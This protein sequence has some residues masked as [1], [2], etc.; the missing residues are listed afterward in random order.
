MK[1]EI[2]DALNYRYA[3]KS[4]DTA[5]SVSDVDLDIIL[6]SLRLAPSSFGLE[7]WGFVVVN[8]KSK[9]QEVA[10]A[11]WGQN[12]IAQA[13]HLLVLCRSTKNISTIIDECIELSAST[14]WI[15]AS[16]LTPYKDMMN[17]AL[18]WLNP[19]QLTSYLNKQVYIAWGFAMLAAAELGIDACPMEGFGPSQVDTILWLTE[20]WLASAM[21]L[22]IWYRSVDDK[23]AT[24]TKVRKSA[25]QVIVKIS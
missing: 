13:S 17:W 12:Q 18:W 10:A 6:E 23:Y 19:E 11:A 8:N 1:Y 20:K 14:K 4:F 15:D 25:D 16:H 21:L 2:I 24:I 7:W 9:Q 5:M 22:P 3:T